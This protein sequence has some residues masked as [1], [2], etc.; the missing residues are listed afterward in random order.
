[1]GWYKTAVCSFISILGGD[2]KNITQRGAAVL[3]K[4]R[5]GS[6]DITMYIQAYFSDACR[7]SRTYETD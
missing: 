2:M 7:L 5:N 1:M 4:R 3:V 6:A